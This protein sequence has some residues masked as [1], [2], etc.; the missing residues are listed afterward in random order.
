[1]DILHLI[2]DYHT[3][4]SDLLGQ[5]IESDGLVVKPPAKEKK[6]RKEIVWSQEQLTAIKN[7]GTKSAVDLAIELNLPVYGFNG[8]F[9]LF[10]F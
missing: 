6:E 4:L 10:N 9:I 2:H 3:K 1:M 8:K 7:R 5:L